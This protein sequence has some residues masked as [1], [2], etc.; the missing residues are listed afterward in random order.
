MESEHKIARLGIQDGTVGA[1]YPVALVRNITRRVVIR[2]VPQQRTAQY[3][4]VN[5][6][7]GGRFQP[8]GKKPFDGNRTRAVIGDVHPQF[9]ERGV[10]YGA[11][12]YI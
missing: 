9:G 8:K 11:E 7:R 12:G 5:L 3:K 6:L 10:R 1:V 4:P 2:R